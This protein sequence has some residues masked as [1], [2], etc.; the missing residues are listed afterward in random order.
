MIVRS[1]EDSNAIAMDRYNYM[2]SSGIDAQPQRSGVLINELGTPVLPALTNGQPPVGGAMA[3]VPPKPA[4][5]PA[6]ARTRP[7]TAVPLTTPTPIITPAPEPAPLYRPV[8][9]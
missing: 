4:V 8:Q 6:Q 3:G 2:R 5:T 7:G 1:K 9:K